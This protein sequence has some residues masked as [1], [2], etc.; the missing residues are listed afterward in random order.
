MTNSIPSVKDMRDFWPRPATHDGINLTDLLSEI[1]AFALD[2]FDMIDVDQ[3]GFLSA[4]E[5]EYAY[6]HRDLDRRQK[7]YVRFLLKNVDRIA[8]AHDDHDDHD[9]PNHAG[10]SRNDIV[11]ISRS[12][13]VH[14]FAR[15]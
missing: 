9:G 6:Q 5:L 11:G 3:N 10:I 13:L 7:N 4:T 12:D 14:Y 8:L 15:M 1:K 2:T